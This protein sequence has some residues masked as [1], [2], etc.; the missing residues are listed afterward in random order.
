MT[1]NPYLELFLRHDTIGIDMDRT[2]VGY[3]PTK[4]L[5]W[6]AISKE[7]GRRS[8][9]IVTFRHETATET[10]RDL[11]DEG[12]PWKE[13]VFE[14][15]VHAPEDISRNSWNTDDE[16]VASWKP[17]VCRWAGI[18]LM[19]DDREDLKPYFV[20][21]GIRYVNPHKL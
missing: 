18:T 2:L 12:F 17:F 19:V 21:Y 6:E 16:R 11:I 5:L 4:T 7:C 1:G 10:V 20:R 14:R 9:W 13:G 3:N 8:F 15:I